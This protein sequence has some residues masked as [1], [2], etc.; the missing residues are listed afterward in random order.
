MKKI[1][2]TDKAPAAVGPYSQAVQSGDKLY[3]SGQIAIDPAVGKLID[4]DTAAQVEQIMKN[5]TAVLSAANLTME[6]VV[7]TTI[8]MTDISEYGAINEAYGRYFA[9]NPPARAAIAVA[10]LPA[11]AQVEIEAIAEIS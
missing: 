8:Y 1:I 5:I 4:G 7:K 2:K 11:G 10:A 9:E 6:N 3:L